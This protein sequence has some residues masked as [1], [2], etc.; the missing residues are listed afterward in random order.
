MVVKN[1]LRN[2]G[3]QWTPAEEKKLIKMA[4]AN[5]PTGVIGFKLGRPKGGV[6]SKASDLKISLKPTNKSPYNRR[7]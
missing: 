4:K 1:Y 6:S 2:K 3:K 5:T 7:K